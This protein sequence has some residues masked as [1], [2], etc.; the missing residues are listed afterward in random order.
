MNEIITLYEQTYGTTPLQVEQLPQA[1]SSRIYYRLY[2]KDASTVVG[3]SNTNRQE[4]ECFIYLARCFKEAGVH[5]P[6]IYAQNPSTTAYLI[7]D[8]GQDSLYSLLKE[9]RDHN[10]N[11]TEKDYQLLAKVVRELPLIQI[12]GA[13]HIDFARCLSPQSFDRQSAMFDL[14]YFKYSFFKPAN[15]GFD[16]VRLEKD[17][18]AFAQDLT[19]ATEKEQYF[20]Y[21]D[22]QARNVLIK[23]GTPYFIDFQ[24][25]RRGPLPY[26]LVSFLWQS[27]AHFPEDLRQRLIQIYIQEVSQL[28]PSFDEES[29]RKQ[30]QA[31]VLFRI[32]QV[33]GAYGLRGFVENKK[34]FLDSIPLAIEN[35]RLQLQTG[36]ADPYPYLKEILNKLCVHYSCRQPKQQNLQ[37]K[38]NEPL[39]AAQKLIVRIYS[40]SY[41]KGIPEDESGNGG[42]YVFDCRGVHNPGQYERYKTL[43]GLDQPVIQFLENDGEITSFLKSVYALAEAHV[44]RY[45]ERGFTS[46]MFSF[47]CTGGQHRSVYSAQHLAEHLHQ[48]Y[49][50]EIHLCHRE[51]QIQTVLPSVR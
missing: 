24:G 47:G 22:F 13:Q 3:V 26:D 35:L 5:V 7:E 27:S 28:V 29:F 10:Y 9:A 18:L 32:M 36:A 12:V 17:L 8:L 43:T 2:G 51:Q 31:F 4:N 40:F 48:K 34:Y 45:L 25:G 14:N 23:E 44:E 11:Y 15:I 30:L 49:G 19:L 46:L 33:L 50:I 6:A 39:P 20:L 42:G 16:E 21:R 1:G 41:K 37:S 38:P